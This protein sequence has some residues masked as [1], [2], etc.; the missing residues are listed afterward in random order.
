MVY[1]VDKICNADNG[2]EFEN[3]LMMITISMEL[4][5]LRVKKAE[6]LLKRYQIALMKM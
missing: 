5:I 3:G 6:V 4:C 2:I 1:L